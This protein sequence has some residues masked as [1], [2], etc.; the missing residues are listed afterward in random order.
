[1]LVASFLP[2]LSTRDTLVLH[3]TH[4]LLWCLFHSFGLGLV[5][6]AQ[7]ERKFLV[8]HFLKHYHYPRNDNGKGAV[9]EAFSNWKS[10]Y[11]TSM[12]MTYGRLHNN[13]EFKN[14]WLNGRRYLASFIG[15]AWKTYCIPHNWTVGNE[16][17]RHTLG[18]VCSHVALF[19]A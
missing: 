10:I 13:F 15:I 14:A 11:N 18:V 1:M 17:L 3:F 19:P 6:Q 12:C 9:I 4:A 7:S 2:T 8:R 5:L 16:L